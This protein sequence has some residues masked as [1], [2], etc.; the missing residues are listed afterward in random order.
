MELM[1]NPWVI[2]ISSA[3]FDLIASGLMSVGLNLGVPGSVY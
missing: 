3:F 2:L 1:E